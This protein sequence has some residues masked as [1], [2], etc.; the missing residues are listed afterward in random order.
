VS[1]HT[2]LSPRRRRRIA[3]MAGLAAVVV[4]AGSASAYWRTNASG[5]GTGTVGQGKNVVSVAVDPTTGL[6]YP[7]TT[8][9]GDLR[10][11]FTATVNA[12][13]TAITQDSSRSVTV[14]GGVGGSPACTGSS[15]TLTPI[16]G[17]NI[18]L[19][20]NTPFTMTFSS[21]VSMAFSAPSSCQNASFSI[22]VI[23][24]ATEL[25]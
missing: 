14:T 23:L 21:V 4:V 8:F 15:V 25:P 12:K 24:T 9:K 11:T 18:N 7:S 1:A 5:N 19:T 2:R 22:P 16:T 20:A 13:V 3:T 10:A 17:Q 6:L